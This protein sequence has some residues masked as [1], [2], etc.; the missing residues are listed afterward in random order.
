VLRNERSGFL[1]L[2]LPSSSVALHAAIKLAAVLVLMEERPERIE[3]RPAAAL[4][5]HG[6]LDDLV[7]PDQHCRRD[8]QPEPLGRPYI[9]G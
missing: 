8:R 3:E 1:C 6:L 2:I 9:D 5:E 7:G 4:V